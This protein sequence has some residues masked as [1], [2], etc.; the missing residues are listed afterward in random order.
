M[1]IQIR[2]GGYYINKKN[3]VVGPATQDTCFKNFPWRLGKFT[4]TTEGRTSSTEFY[5]EDLISECNADG[6]PLRIDMPLDKIIDKVNNR[7]WSAI[8]VKINSDLVNSSAFEPI[9]DASSSS[10]PASVTVN[11]VE[12]VSKATI[13]KAAAIEPLTAALHTQELQLKVGQLEAENAA[14][15][16]NAHWLTLQRQD[17]QMKIEEL[18]AENTL[19][20][21][22]SER[23]LEE[24]SH[25]E[26]IADER[27]KEMRRLEAD[28]KRGNTAFNQLDTLFHEVAGKWEAEN[29]AL[30]EQLNLARATAE[31]RYDAIVHWR[32]KNAGLQQQWE[33][34]KLEIGKLREQL[35]ARSALPDSA[36]TLEQ[37]LAFRDKILHGNDGHRQWLTEEF[38]KEFVTPKPTGDAAVVTSEWCNVYGPHPLLMSDAHPTKASTDRAGVS[39][40][41][42]LRFDTLN[43]ITT[44]ELEKI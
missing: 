10:H 29:A 17:L 2:K 4:Y 28:V 38:E 7:D 12:Y 16:H 40:I 8:V 36:I 39:R 37:I 24:I 22:L 18:K 43:G 13:C 25:W 30:T 34:Q 27:E 32:E 20:K 9:S 3:N 1:T 11:G 6:S 26:R 14:L 41:A 42:C 31:R 19:L 23:R 44:C 15:Q 5:P 21:D 35:A 33:N